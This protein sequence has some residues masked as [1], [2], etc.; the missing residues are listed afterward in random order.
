MKKAIIATAIVLFAV[1]AASAQGVAGDW[2]GTLHADRANLHLVLHI[3]KDDGGKLKATLDIVDQAAYGIKV[4]S[5]S[6]KKSSLNLDVDVEKI[7]GTYWGK[8]SG[9]GNTISGVW[10]KEEGQPAQLDFKRAPAPV[11]AEH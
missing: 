4:D 6:L 10:R 5:I 9:D 2:Q 11:K 7:D 8:V 3:S 1:C